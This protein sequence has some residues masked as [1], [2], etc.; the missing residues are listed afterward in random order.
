MPLSSFE[1]IASSPGHAGAFSIAAQYLIK[2]GKP[3]NLGEALLG[4]S[5]LDS[6]KVTGTLQVGSKV[7][8]YLNQQGCGQIVKLELNTDYGLVTWK[9]VQ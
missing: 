7:N 2:E 6:T 8:I 5:F 4:G 1:A 9:F 3:N